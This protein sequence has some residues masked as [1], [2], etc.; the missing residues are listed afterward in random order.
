M[1]DLD[2]C[3]NCD[4][5]LIGEPIPEYPHLEDCEEQK[6]RSE[7]R[8]HGRRCFCKPYGDTTHFRRV[9]GHEVRGVYDGVLF[10]SCPDCGHAWPRWDDG[11]GRLSFE[12]AH[13]VMK[14]NEFRAQVRREM[15]ATS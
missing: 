10:W 7:S 5:T 8:G 14:H 3:P 9:M 11:A 12:S 15:G 2:N 4:A 13:Y 1:S 6:D